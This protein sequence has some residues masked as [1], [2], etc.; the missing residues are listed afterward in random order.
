[1]RRL[2]TVGTGTSV[3][4]LVHQFGSLNS[5]KDVVPTSQPVNEQHCAWNQVCTRS[6]AAAHSLCDSQCCPGPLPLAFFI[7]IWS[8]LACW[9]LM[10]S[11]KHLWKMYIMKTMSKHQNVAPNFSFHCIFHQVFQ[12]LLY[13]RKQLATV[14]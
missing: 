12:V 11:S 7:C 8:L 1:M 5:C 13:Y 3:R 6:V 9:Y 10:G 14:L 4:S 2:G